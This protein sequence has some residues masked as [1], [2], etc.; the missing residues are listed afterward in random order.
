MNVLKIVVDEL[1]KYCGECSLA[2]YS[3][4]D[5]K[6]RCLVVTKQ[7]G[8]WTRPSWC[9]L[10]VEETEHERW[11]RLT[12]ENDNVCIYCDGDGW[13]KCLERTGTHCK[14]HRKYVEVE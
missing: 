5:E 6:W 8:E 9:P 4:Y 1:P 3:L 12:L 11:K 2:D 14:G 13:D 7:V 10:V